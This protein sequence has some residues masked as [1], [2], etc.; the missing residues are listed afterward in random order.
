MMRHW[1]CVCVCHGG[2]AEW[3]V[4]WYDGMWPFVCVSLWRLTLL[5]CSH[6]D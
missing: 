4:G 2:G 3:S 6:G 1:L 5:C